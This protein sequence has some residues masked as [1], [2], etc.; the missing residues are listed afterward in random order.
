MKKLIL[1]S[2]ASLLCLV[3]SAQVK[4]IVLDSATKKPVEG[5]VVALYKDTK[6]PDTIYSAT[7]PKG[8]YFFDKAPSSD[9]RISVSA[10]AYKN[11]KK[12]RRIY[13]SES[14]LDLGTIYLVNTA[15]V[16]DEIIIHS[17]P[18]TV[19][20]DTIEYRGDAFKVKENAV[21]EDLLKKLPGI[22]VDK[23]GNINAQGR[24][25]TKVK[26]NGKDFFGGD[27]G[28][29]TKELPADIVDKIQV[30]NDYG[31]QANISGI[32]DGDP[33]KVMNIQLKKDKNA[34]I[35]GRLT[36]GTGNKGRYQASLSGNYFRDTRQVSIFTNSNNIGQ[37]SVGAAGS[38]K[39]LQESLTS[40]ASAQPGSGVEIPIGGINEGIS[41][42]H[43]IG[44]NYRDQWSK[45]ISVYGSYTFGYRN[46]RGYKIISQQNIF[47]NEIYFNNQENNFEGKNEMHR[48]FFNVEYNIDSFN[49][50]KF[51]PSVTIG[52][53]TGV[54]DVLFDYAVIS[55]KSSEGNF[56]LSNRSFSPGVSGNLLFNHRFKK[57]GRNFSVNINAGTS[58]SNTQQD[59]RN[60]TIL[61]N[62]ALTTTLLLFNAQQ[63]NNH[64]YGIRLTYTEPV[65][66]M[67]FIDLSLSHNLSFSGN[68]KSVY[69]ID[70]I[71]GLRYF[72]SGL[73]NEYENNFYNNRVN[74]SLR[75]TQKKYN[76][77]FGLSFQPV[78]LEGFSVSKDSAYRPVKR[79]NIF[80][81]ARISYN[82]SKTRSLTVSYRGDA[83]QPGFSQ[84]QDVIDSSNLQYRTRGNPNLRPSALHS[85]NLLY[86]NFSFSNGTVLFTSMTL[87]TVRN[88]VV[89]NTIAIGTSGA[90]LTIPENINGNYNI[91]GYYNLSRPFNERAFVFTLNGILNYN[92]NVSITESKKV[93]GKNWVLGQGLSFEM[94]H[95][96]W[97]QL[98]CAVNYNL[99]SINYTNTATNY[100]NDRYSSWM[101]T[102]NIDINIFKSLLFKYDIEYISYQGLTGQV[103]ENQAV[104]N[105][106][107]EKQ[108]FNKRNGVIRLQALDILDQNSNV[109]RSVSGNSIIDSRSNRLSRYIMLTFSC[110]FQKFKG[111]PLKAN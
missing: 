75:T 11:G 17:L 105:A 92:N 72:N 80:P 102:G 79:I 85:L 55:G 15:V 78:S 4:G 16:M 25:I 51:S 108:L 109:Y 47:S 38:G 74:I 44:F 35:F 63:N 14:S 48:I 84:L 24:M 42:L 90:Q 7:N 27:P 111:K 106:S 39:S 2:L 71:S 1:F 77:A 33:E 81:V 20:E 82:F 97:L 62:P 100:Q 8:E 32:K 83:Q 69:D 28:T 10:V 31:D 3:T 6:D 22:S 95:R 13:G 61:F 98:T 34:G 101:L 56:N 66:K 57:R 65:S 45:K 103:G 53:N 76:Y 59:S 9:F 86:N 89:N 87:S 29:A 37:S 21:V 94:N 60:N 52:K 26:V 67:K 40:N 68:N 12:F 41:S 96:E 104:M 64:N 54:T 99:N 91:S 5:A 18:V 88:Q 46:T 70:A 49:F 73:S 58:R 93:T 50:L 19:K 110:R 43:S 36:A 23:N 107:I 30:I